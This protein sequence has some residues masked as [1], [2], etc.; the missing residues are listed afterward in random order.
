MGPVWRARIL[1]L[2]FVLL[3]MTNVG[4]TQRG[5]AAP[6][7]ETVHAA[8]APLR[9]SAQPDQPIP[10]NASGGDDIGLRSADPRLMDVKHQVRDWVEA[11]LATVGADADPAALAAQLNAALQ[12]ADLFCESGAG[13]P[14]RC[15]DDKGFSNSIGFLAP[16]VMER[17]A[18]GT[19]M[20]LRTG[21]GIRCGTDDS[22]YAY[23]WR[24]GAWRRL[25]QSE[26]DIRPSRPYAPQTLQS[27]Q[28]S[29]PDPV[30]GAR[31]ILTLGNQSWCSSLWYPVYIRLWQVSVDSGAVALVDE[32]PAAYLG[33]HATPIVGRL[34]SAE[35]LVGFTAGGF[36]DVAMFHEAVRHYRVDGGKVV[37]VG[38]VALTPSDFAQEWLKIAWPEALRWGA[39]AA[40]VAALK[41]WHKKWWDR[42]GALGEVADAQHCRAD[43]EMWQVGVDFGDTAPELGQAYF[44]VRW[45]QSDRFQM[46]DIASQPWLDCDQ[47]DP[48]ALPKRSLFTPQEW[49]DVK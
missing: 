33:M 5:Q 46:V 27:V 47:P 21:M 14:D 12:A 28:V 11:R 1:A 49:G 41:A 42:H 24:D 32:A 13:G 9:S 6:S 44:L 23:E 35:A 39:P 3:G 48:S 45:R 30:G 8:L 17:A 18:S 40:N 16:V 7:P 37:R 25:W 31:L 38:P 2:G 19:I 34:T 4:W 20:V 15:A 43:P 36:D 26:Q 22:A 10:Y 29:Q